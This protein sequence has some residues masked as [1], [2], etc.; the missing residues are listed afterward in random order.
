MR[1]K[2][3]DIWPIWHFALSRKTRLGFLLA[4]GMIDVLVGTPIYLITNQLMNIRGTTVIDPTMALDLVIPIIP[5]TVIIYFTL[6]YFFYPLPLFSMP[7]E[8]KGR[9]EALVMS[10]AL[11]VIVLVS[12][13]WFVISPAEVYLRES[14]DLNDMHPI[15]AAMFEGLWFIDS[16][17]NAWPSL[18]VSTAG[19]F[20]LFAMRW[21][22]DQPLKKWGTCTIWILMCLSILTTKQHFI[23]DLITALMLLGAVWKWHVMPTLEKLE[24]MTTDEVTS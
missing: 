1:E 2:F 23:L 12:N 3:F 6:F 18:H 21:W 20:T 5:W 13:I 24:P 17:Y 8:K 10:Q 4:M 9:Y 7:K 15:F 19:I 22:S 11:I 16:P 14:I